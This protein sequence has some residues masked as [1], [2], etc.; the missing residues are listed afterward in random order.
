M[1]SVQRL[2]TRRHE[3]YTYFQ[4]VGQ[5]MEF[6]TLGSM[7]ESWAI[8][9]RGEHLLSSIETMI[10]RYLRETWTW[11]IFIQLTL[12]WRSISG[13]GIP[14]LVTWVSW[15]THLFLVC[16]G[17]MKTFS[18]GME[19]LVEL[20]PHFLEEYLGMYS[21]SL[22]HTYIG[23]LHVLIEGPSKLQVCIGKDYF[24]IW[25]YTTTKTYD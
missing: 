25:W 6:C 18:V 3:I 12:F 8:G 4:C 10:P 19:R 14:T 15:I 17:H 20:W 5:L 7:A 1:T 2:S 23:E 21:L 11:I 24:P 9:W 16:I 13:N 22:I